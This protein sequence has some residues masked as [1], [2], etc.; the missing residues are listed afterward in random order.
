M[1]NINNPVQDMKN[2]IKDLKESILNTPYKNFEK[3]IKDYSFKYAIENYK[4]DESIF[5]EYLERAKNVKFQFIDT[6]TSKMYSYKDCLNNVFNIEDKEIFLVK[7]ASE[8]GL[9]LDENS[10][11]KEFLLKNDNDIDEEYYQ[12]MVDRTF[13]SIFYQFSEDIKKNDLPIVRDDNYIADDVAKFKKDIKKEFK[14]YLDAQSPIM[15]KYKKIIEIAIES[16]SKDY[17]EQRDFGCETSV[18]YLKRNIK[19]LLKKVDFSFTYSDEAYID[20]RANQVERE[21][22]KK[23]KTNLTELEETKKEKEIDL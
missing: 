14:D 12:Y 5:N 23:E 18:K 15:E 21:Y 4:F 10:N 2:A 1:E 22:R 6:I 11:I 17:I 13:E 7:N 9:N 20:K 19:D 8:L 3:E 16:E